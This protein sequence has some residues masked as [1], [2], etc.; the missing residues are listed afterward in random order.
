MER[1]WIMIICSV[2]VHKDGQGAPD[3]LATDKDSDPA[4][5]STGKD[6]VVSKKSVS[7]KE[8]KVKCHLSGALGPSNKPREQ[9]H[10]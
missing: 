9:R 8:R 10:Q 7:D 3:N 5:T 2:V 6:N 1:G 4:T